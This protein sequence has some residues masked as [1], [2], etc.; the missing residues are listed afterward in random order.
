MPTVPSLQNQVRP[1]AAPNFQQRPLERTFAQDI[2]QGIANLG[3][4]QQQIEQQERQKADEAAVFD[5]T[6]KLG[7]AENILL[8]DPQTG[9]LNRRGQ[10]AFDLEAQYGPMLEKEASTIWQGLKT[11][12]QRFVFERAL[13]DTK[14]RVAQDL[15]RHESNQRESFYDQA[16]S[17]RLDV[18]IDS[19]A[20]AGGDPQRIAAELANQRSVLDLAAR[21]KGWDDVT[22]AR[23]IGDFE[24]RT[25]A[26]VINALIAGNR[27]D[28]AKAYFDLNADKLDSSIRPQ[29]EG[30]IRAG[31][32]ESASNLIISAFEKG[33][34]QG[35]EALKG[36]DDQGLSIDEQIEVRG[37]VRAAVNALREE[38]RNDNLGTI[39]ALERSITQDRVPANAE[40]IAASLYQKGAYTSDQYTNVLQAIDTSRMQAAKSNAGVTE[41]AAALSA[42]LPLDP[43]S[44]RQQKALDAMF[45]ADTDG[46]GV[47][48]DAWQAQ[49]SAYAARTRTL[50]GQVSA[51]TRQSMRSPDPAIAAK[52]AQFYGAVAASAPDAVSKFDDDTRSFAGVVNRM[53][54]S[55][56]K[57]ETAVATARDIVFDVKKDVIELRKSQYQ[58]LAKDSDSKL[59]DFVDRDFDTW[60]K[61]Q[62]TITQALSTD[63]ASQTSRYFQKTGDIDLARDLAWK[64]LMRVYGETRVNGEP[65]LMAMPPERYGITPETVRGE[66]TS[67]LAENPQADGSMAGEIMLVPDALTQRAVTSA[68]DGQPIRPSYKAVTKTG[69]LVVDKYGVP[70]RY[71]LPEPDLDGRIAEAQKNAE[72]E[73]TQARLIRD[74]VRNKPQAA[75]RP[76]DPA[77]VE[78][79]ARAQRESD[80]ADA[81]MQAAFALQRTRNQ[82]KPLPFEPPAEPKPPKKNPRV[83]GYVKGR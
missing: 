35:Y 34:S 4:V 65:M 44:E 83:V 13:G 33:T 80:S 22:K 54:E 62:P 24:S 31:A 2:G 58:A 6:T 9:A 56:T 60:T 47:G 28:Q 25:H 75:G 81:R 52:A 43:N 14:A 78:Q 69:D 48:S 15:A 59:L 20:R 36:L 19:A 16:A 27:P 1:I 72:Q 39:N 53:L 8:N 41:I 30:R 49:A 66:I 46:V 37:K 23:K 21:R 64:D 82:P 50:P 12:R 40:S 74:Y 71:V 18:S 45:K 38:R 55:G 29:I 67:F 5:A 61:Q 17:D 3:Q 68:L 77:F 32:L 63:F 76:Q 57:P 26:S 42:G 70:L 73:V 11:D 51:W 79:R 7:R 10:D